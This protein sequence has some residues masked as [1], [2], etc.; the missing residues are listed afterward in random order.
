[1][2]VLCGG[3][4]CS[5]VETSV[6]E[7]ERRGLRTWPNSKFNLR[8][9]EETMNEAKPFEVE[10]RLVWEAWKRVKANGGSAGIDNVDLKTYDSDIGKNLYKLWNRMSSGSYFPK[11]VKLVEIPKPNGGKRPLGIP[12]VED[13]VAQMAVVMKITD[14]LEAIFHEDSYGYRPMR[15][16]HDAISKA[17]ERCNENHW[18]LDMDISKFFDTIDHGLLMKAVQKH[19][20]ERWILLYIERW[21]K[22]PYRTSNGTIVERTM[23]VPQ[24]SVIGPVLAN[25]FLTYVFDKWMAINFPTIPFERYADDTICHCRTE[26]QAQYLKNCLMKRFE[27]CG[28]KLNEEKTKIVYCKDSNRKG[29]SEH[30]SFDFLGYTYRPRAARNSKTGQNFTAFSPAIS[31][32]SMMKIKTEIRSWN[33]NRQTQL[34]LTQIAEEY[35]PKIRGWLNYY[36]RFGKSEFRKVMSYLNER[37]ARWVK[38]KYKRFHTK[39]GKAHDWLVQCATNNRRLFPHWMG[40]YIPYPRLYKLR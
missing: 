34:S 15:S 12:T 1:M 2:L 25:L 27:D 17:W 3:Q 22:V 29:D 36:S 23:G 39:L 9:K 24:G 13:R 33:L 8:I 38:R 11:A 31:K 16:A 30:T 4:P 7:V 14:R 21:L 6:M 40:G 5:S 35:N 20:S 18:V 37:L 10:K 19:I 28:L 26:R 32:K